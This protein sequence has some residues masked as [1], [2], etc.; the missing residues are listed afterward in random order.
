MFEFQA[1]VTQEEQSASSV[2]ERKFNEKEKEMQIIRN[3]T[4]GLA[5]DLT[6][7]H[8]GDVKIVST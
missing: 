8:F 2:S 6:A 3:K 4:I 7:G 1:K 5:L